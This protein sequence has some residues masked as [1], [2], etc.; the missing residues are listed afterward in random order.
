METLLGG[1]Y[2]EVRME[3]T[4]YKALSKSSNNWQAKA[5]SKKSPRS[6]IREKRHGVGEKT[7]KSSV[8]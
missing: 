7:R 5:K 8:Q 1:H 6:R 2:N 3:K 4:K